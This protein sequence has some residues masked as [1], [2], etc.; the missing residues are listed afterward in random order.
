MRVSERGLLEKQIKSF[1][2]RLQV[3]FITNS[4]DI[5]INNAFRTKSN[6]YSGIGE[7]G[8]FYD[9]IIGRPHR[10]DLIIAFQKSELELITVDFKC[11]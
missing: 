6:N 10:N 8:V 4:F 11:N 9:I 5:R 1:G 3:S 2:S 7:D